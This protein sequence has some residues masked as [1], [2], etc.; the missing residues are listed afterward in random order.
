[1]KYH[2]AIIPGLAIACGI[3][4]G[5]DAKDKA[6]RKNITVITAHG[7]AD[8]SSEISREAVK[9]CIVTLPAAE[10][11]E[12]EVVSESRFLK[13]INGDPNKN[14]W[15]KVYTATITINYQ[16][17]KKDLLIV[18][19]KSVEGKEPTMREVDKRLPQSKEFVSNPADGDTYAGRSN[20]QYY[21][22]KLDDAVIDVKNRAKVWLKQ[23]GPLLCADT[24]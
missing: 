14:E 15:A 7:N 13:E 4:M 20:R 3:A 16:V 8:G 23:Q 5:A 17:F 22:T 12:P 1:M 18:T 10:A 24:K 19:T 9:E 6:E 21:F 2:F 11:L